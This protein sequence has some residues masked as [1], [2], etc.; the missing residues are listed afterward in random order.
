VQAQVLATLSA[1]Q[2]AITAGAL[3]TATTIGEIVT[4]T[5]LALFTLL[6][7]CVAA[8]GSQQFLLGVVPANPRTRVDVAGRRGVAALVS[9]VRATA[10]GTSCNRSSSGAR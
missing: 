6:F 5:L 10:G 8:S 9:Y 2:S 4:E 3:T 1:S 7:S